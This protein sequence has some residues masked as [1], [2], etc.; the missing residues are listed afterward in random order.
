MCDLD[1]F[2]KSL[3]GREKSSAQVG[4][5]RGGRSARVRCQY[6]SLSSKRACHPVELARHAFVYGAT[7]S[8][9]KGTIV[10]Q[11]LEPSPSPS[12]SPSPQ[13]VSDRDALAQNVD[14]QGRQVI[15]VGCGAGGLVRW[16]RTQGAAPVGVECGPVM[17]AQALDQDP[18]HADSYVD[19]VGQ[20]LPFEDGSSD[21]VTFL[22]S[23]HHVPADEMRNALAEAHRVLRSGGVCWVAEPTPEGPGY[24]LGR[25]ID[26]ER[27]VRGLAQEALAD[28]LNLGFARVET[29]G[30]L[31]ES[32]YSNFAAFEA[33]VVGIDPDRAAAMEA[34]R[35]AARAAFADNARR[36]EVGYAFD[37]PVTWAKLHVD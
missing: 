22:Y 9:N 2:A 23:L 8:S 17:L 29:G 19:A 28:A 6:Q 37:Q 3:A 18:D 10:S 7:R 35:E 25:L 31:T 26:D 20:S 15:D 27:H 5:A 24:Q 33:R 36:T 21:V 14:V 1:R 16:L 4:S 34:N 32:V 30:Y 12:P 13:Y 11:P